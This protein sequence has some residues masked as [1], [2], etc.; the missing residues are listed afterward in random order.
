[1]R[2]PIYTTQIRSIREVAPEV[3]EITLAPPAEPF[4]F[5]PGQWISLQL[6]VGEKP[7]LVR[8]YSLAAPPSSSGELVL[9]LDR[10]PRGLA[11]DYLFSIGEGDEIRFGG[12][13]GNFVLPEERAPLLWIA[14]YTGIVPF[15][16][17]LLHLK[18]HPPDH[19]V[20]LLYS[21]PYP[22]DLV[23]QAELQRITE[24]VPWLEFIP[25]LESPHPEW[26]GKLGPGPET[27]YQPEGWVEGF[28]KELAEDRQDQIPMICGIRAF[29]RPMRDFF[30]NLGYERRAVKWENYD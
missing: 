27:D 26:A 16:A 2:S 22:V 29:V 28:L 30:Y 6:P 13:L 1:L 9:C 19:P 15:R 20:T 25:L 17:M 21:A 24:E 3:R 11:S 7:P 18:T 5:L 8:A 10:V 23:Y 4:D 14:R 12:P